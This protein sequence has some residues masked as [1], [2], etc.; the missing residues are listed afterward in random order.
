M[1]VSWRR[2]AED[3]DVTIAGDRDEP[4]ARIVPHLTQDVPPSGISDL[5]FGQTMPH[6]SPSDG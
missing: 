6:L 3:V 4:A 2:S 1:T 5:Q